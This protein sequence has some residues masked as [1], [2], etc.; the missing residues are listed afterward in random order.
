MDESKDTKVIDRILDLLKRD[1]EHNIAGLARAVGVSD[2]TVHSWKTRRNDPPCT[3]ADAIARYFG[4]TL[5]WLLA[6]RDPSPNQKIAE[7]LTEDE[8]SAIRMLR[9]LP[10]D[11][12]FMFI[13]ELQGYVRAYGEQDK[14]L[15]EGKRLSS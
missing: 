8:I 9:T 1:R 5:D 15:D 6:G 7:D 3:Y 12:R 4:V 11:K 14:Y 13:G 10:D 2:T